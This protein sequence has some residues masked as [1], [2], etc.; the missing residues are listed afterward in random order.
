[1]AVDTIAGLKAKMPLG[2]AA[3][4]SVQDLHDIVDTLEDRTTQALVTA[5]ANY[6]VGLADN[7]RKIVVNAATAVTVTL[8]NTTP[9]GF[10]LTLIQMGAGA[11]V[12]QVTGGTLV[13]RGTH[14][15][16]AGQY[17]I[18]FVVCTANTG[19]SPQIVLSGDTAP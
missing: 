5:T 7:R 17:A 19:T 8:P 9:V 15:R 13:S 11:A 1:M 12:V 18:A 4:T 16:T 14:T 2:T 3:G 6:G 10:E